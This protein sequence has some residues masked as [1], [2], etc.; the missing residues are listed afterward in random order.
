MLLTTAASLLLAFFFAPRLLSPRPLADLPEQ[1]T[2]RGQSDSTLLFPR[3]LLLARDGVAGEAEA[4]ATFELQ[5]VEGAEN[6]HVEVFLHEGDAFEEGQLLQSLRSNEPEL[7]GGPLRPGRYT[8]QAW[9]LVDG[10][11]RELGAR[12][13]EIRAD[14][15]LSERLASLGTSPSTKELVQAV[16]VLHDAGYR[17][18]AR[19]LARSL[20]DG[21]E[22]DAYLSP[23]GR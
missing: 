20:P 5:A 6:Y 16:R 15:E 22:K 11:E 3:G 13:F 12:E 18:D 8:W 2:Y 23:P 21:Q 19:E 14:E 1:P 9:A 10:L 17:T 7:A 4:L